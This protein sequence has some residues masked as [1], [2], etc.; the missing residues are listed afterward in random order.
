[1]LAGTADARALERA[2]VVQPVLWAVMVA[3]AAAWES[4]GVIPDAVAGHSQGEIAAAMVAG[5]LSL[6]EAARV[7][8]VRSRALARAGRAGGAM[9]AVAWPRRRR[10]DAV[11]G[12]G[13][14]GCGW[15]R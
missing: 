7:V 2:E 15:R 3:L 1:M 13:R 10:E 12:C 5:V 14:A 4:V 11:A 8:A 6:E 9:A